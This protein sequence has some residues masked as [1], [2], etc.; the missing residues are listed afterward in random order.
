MQ[1]IAA[2]LTKDLYLKLNPRC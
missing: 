1:S 2:C